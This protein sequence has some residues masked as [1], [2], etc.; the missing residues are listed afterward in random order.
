MEQM[1]VGKAKQRGV[2][3]NAG[4]STSRARKIERLSAY[5]GNLDR[6]DGVILLLPY[7]YLKYKA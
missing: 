4:N 6:L 7:V 3:H 2:T 1:K 5:G